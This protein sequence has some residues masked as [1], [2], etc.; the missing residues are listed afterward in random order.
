MSRI[1]IRKMTSSYNKGVLLIIRGCPVAPLVID[2]LTIFV[3][4]E[5]GNNGCSFDVFDER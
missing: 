4:A 3:M 5:Y 1:I 2:N